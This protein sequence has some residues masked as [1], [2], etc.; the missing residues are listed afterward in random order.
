ML[1]VQWYTLWSTDIVIENCYLL[2]LPIN[3]VIFHIVMI[4]YQRVT[5]I[6][7]NHV[8]LFGIS[9]FQQLNWNKAPC[10]KNIFDPTM[11][12]S[13]FLGY[14]VILGNDLV[15]GW[16]QRSNWIFHWSHFIATSSGRPWHIPTAGPSWISSH[17]WCAFPRYKLVLFLSSN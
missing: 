5:D 14:H 6:I 16:W 12:Y 1:I 2:Y 8:Y 15:L 10:S 9:E 13:T 4:V 11:S 17:V 7:I 3:I